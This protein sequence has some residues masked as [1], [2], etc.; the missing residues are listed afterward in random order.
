MHHMKVNT[1]QLLLFFTCMSNTFRHILNLFTFNVCKQRIALETLIQ[2]Q[3]PW[4]G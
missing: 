3:K 2:K 4:H 1:Y